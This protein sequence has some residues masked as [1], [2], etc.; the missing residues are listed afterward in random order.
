MA[1][2]REQTLEVV[3]AMSHFMELRRPEEHIRPLLD[4]DYRIDGQSVII[5]EV[6]PRHDKPEIKLEIPVAKTTFVQTTGK[7]KVY[8]MR[9]NLKWYGYDPNP[10]VNT[11]LAFAKLVHE[12]KHFCFFG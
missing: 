1:F 5:F 3:E 12:D 11:I 8:W 10:Q 4:F 6:R 7:W 2:T 9:S